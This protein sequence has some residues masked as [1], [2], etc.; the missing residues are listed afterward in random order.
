MSIFRRCLTLPT[1]CGSFSATTPE[2]AQDLEKTLQDGLLAAQQSAGILTYLHK[3]SLCVKHCWV[4]MCVA[5]SDW[6]NINYTESMLTQVD[7]FQSYVSGMILLY[8]TA[9]LILCGSPQDAWRPNFDLAGTLL[10]LLEFCQSLDPVA[11]HFKSRISC[12]YKTIQLL[13]HTHHVVYVDN[14]DATTSSTFTAPFISLFL[15]PLSG[16]SIMHEVVTQISKQL[17]EPYGDE[18]DARTELVNQ[19]SKTGHISAEFANVSRYH[20]GSTSGGSEED[21]LQR[22]SRMSSWEAEYFADCRDPNH[23]AAR[24]SSYVYSQDAENRS[25]V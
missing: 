9:R 16:Y 23:W 6:L 10:D 3:A 4:T 17:C 19:S 7:R 24:R 8:H 22:L 5:F 14:R 1:G 11:M 15:Q 18:K 13:L 12:H 25:I 2:Q 21:P 20:L